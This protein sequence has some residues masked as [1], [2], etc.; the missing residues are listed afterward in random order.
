MASST[1]RR[2][3]TFTRA[4]SMDPEKNTIMGSDG[5]ACAHDYYKDAAV[6]IV[7]S[8]ITFLGDLSLTYFHSFLYI[9]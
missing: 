9:A 3:R 8:R 5:G 1:K 2:Q 4:S 6:Y 7:G